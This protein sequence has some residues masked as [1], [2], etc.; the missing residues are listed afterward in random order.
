[1]RS[2][3]IVTIPMSPLIKSSPVDEVA[4]VAEEE[5]VDAE[6]CRDGSRYDAVGVDLVEGGEEAG[7]VAIRLLD[8]PAFSCVAVDVVET[9]RGRFLDADGGHPFQDLLRAMTSAAVSPW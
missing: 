4:F 9:M 5:A 2:W 1:M 6:C 8:T 3:R 7:D